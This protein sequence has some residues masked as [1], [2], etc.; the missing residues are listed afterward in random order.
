MEE[1][2]REDAARWEAVEEPTEMMLE[3]DYHEAL[4][5]LRDIIKADPKNHYAYYY[6]GTALFE[7]GQFEA[8]AAAY[9]AAVKLSPKYVGARVGLSHSLRVIDEHRAAM[10]EARKALEIAPGDG[11]AL[12]A[13]GLAQA[14]F[15]DKVSARRSIEAFLHTGPEFEV[16]NEARAMLDKL[17]QPEGDGDDDDSEVN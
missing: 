3:G 6:T 2:D 4:V 15:G 9:R 1:S 10:A 12:Y 14:A 7:I 16:A 13:L 11:D 17:G 8:A 5:R